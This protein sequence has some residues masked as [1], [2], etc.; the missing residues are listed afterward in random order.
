M[1]LLG[2]I[3]CVIEGWS[4]VQAVENNVAKMNTGTL[5]I[6]YRNKILLCSAF[7]LYTFY[8]YQKSIMLITYFPG[9]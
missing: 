3:V 1:V 5:T 7:S 6:I 9:L 4:L 8:M 2:S